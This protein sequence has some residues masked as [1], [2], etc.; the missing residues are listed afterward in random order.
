MAE[1]EFDG[2]NGVERSR[3]FH[4]EWVLP[5]LVRPRRTLPQIVQK[6]TGVWLAPLVLLT[7]FALIMVA[8]GGPIRQAAAQAQ[9]VLPPDFDFYPP[10][11][12]Q[13]YQ[14]GFAARQGFVFIY[15]YPA[16]GVLATIWIGWFLV[17]SL[18][19]LGLTLA[20]S[21]NQNTAVLNLV[22][23]ASLPFVLRYIVQAIYLIST[24]TSITAA[25]LSGFIPSDATGFLLF[26][27]AFLSLVDIYL[28]WYLALLLVGVAIIARV[29][30]IKAIIV[31]AVLSTLFLAIQALP[32]FLLALFGGVQTQRPFFFF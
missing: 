17:G 29:S 15:V 16:L 2:S 27:R 28:I 5:V 13:Q 9:V 6:D 19:H 18:L 32:G 21:R 7:V 25:G 1:I 31:V 11:W 8:A 14:E 20:G 4:F 24:N 12:Q 3:P 30:R 23:W 22:A 26:M 10:E